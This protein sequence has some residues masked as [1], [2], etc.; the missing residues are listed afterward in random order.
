MI[1]IP[2]YASQCSGFFRFS[3][4]SKTLVSAGEDNTVKLWSVK[5]KSLLYSIESFGGSVNHAS[6]HPSGNYIAAAIDDGSIKVWDIR[7][8]FQLVQLYRGNS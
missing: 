2:V 1:V 8:S 7:K 3:P 6:F 4:D 5:E